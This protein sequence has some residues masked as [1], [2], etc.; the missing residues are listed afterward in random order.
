MLLRRWGRLMFTASNSLDEI[1]N[2]DDHG[3]ASGGVGE[4]F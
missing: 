4:P 1:I 3:I 2:T